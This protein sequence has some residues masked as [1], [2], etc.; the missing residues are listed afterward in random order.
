MNIPLAVLER[1]IDDS[2]VAPRIEVLL[3]VGVRHRQ[4]RTRTLILGMLLVLA[5]R[6]PA[7]LTEVHQALTALPGSDKVRPGVLEDWDNGPHLL[8]YRQVERTFG[9]VAGA[10]GKE[11]PD[12]APR[13]VL[14]RTCDDLLEASIPAR[15][16]DASTALAV[17]WTDVETFSRPPRHGTTECADPE[18]SWGHRNSNLPGP[19][20]ELFFGYYLS[21][22]TTTAG[23]HGPAVP[24]LAR[25]MTLT[26]CHLDPARALV[27]VL[28]R[29]AAAGIPLG[30]ILADSGYAHRDAAAWAIPLRAAGAQLIQDLHPHDRGPQGTHHGAIIANG[31]LYC[32]A[33][34]GSCWNSEVLA[35]PPHAAPGPPGGRAGD[36]ARPGR[37]APRRAPGTGQLPAASAGLY[38]DSVKPPGRLSISGC[39]GCGAM[40]Q[41]E[42]CV[43]ACRECRLEL[44]SGG[45]Y[46]E[47]TA[48]AVACRVRIE[49]LCAVVGELA[50]TEPG[51]GEWRVA[52]E[53]LQRSARS[54]LRR[55]RPA[56]GG[57]DDELL[58]PA[59]TVSVWRCQDCGGVDA[60]QPC[61]DVCIWGPADWVDADSYESERSRAAADR[62][63]EQSLAGLLRR[64]AFATPRDGQWERSW[65][66]FQSQARL[67]LRSRQPRHVAGEMAIGQAQ[68]DG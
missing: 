47:L 2:R 53:A 31:N 13:D 62:E 29:M 5:D 64:F 7:C 68:A 9:L 10:L 61:I 26:S 35:R 24:K 25:R 19:K 42:S 34:P 22:A 48:A 14:A 59:E 57:R 3:P 12:G 60:P 36:M 54:A 6:R 40:R 21:A 41:Y 66:A 67:A 44:V 50:R 45:D 43:G 16:K 52:Y 58:S 33:T 11:Q 55:F 28:R 49:G 18:A 51:P 30:D 23:E 37:H 17:D 46:D 39:I 27:P 1:I 63:V 38:S 4:L 20:G 8:T 65:R 15:C 32:P 56:D